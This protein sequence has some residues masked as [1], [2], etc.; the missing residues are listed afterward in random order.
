MCI[1]TYNTRQQQK[2]HEILTE[3]QIKTSIGGKIKRKV[4]NE[5]GRHVGRATTC[6]NEFQIKSASKVH[7]SVSRSG[8]VLGTS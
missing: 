3:E 1:K 8:T 7:A 4:K 5:I 6:F 2:A